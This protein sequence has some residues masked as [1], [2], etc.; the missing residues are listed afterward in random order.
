MSVP[1]LRLE[2]DRLRLY[3]LSAEF[4]T[5]ATFIFQLLNEPSF[6]SNIGDRGVHSLEDARAYLLKGPRPGL[7]DV[8]LGYAL[9]PAFWGRGY[10]AEAAA[11]VLADARARLGLSRIVAITDPANQGSIR[12]LEK[13][14]FGFESLVQLGPGT[15]VLKLFASPPA[16]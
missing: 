15:T 1:V 10:A 11:A 2:T 5:D 9:L 13:L 7:Q 6:L 12:V 4:A 8:D 16:R 14:G 3:E